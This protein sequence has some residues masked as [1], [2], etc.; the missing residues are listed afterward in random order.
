MIIC[1]VRSI[2]HTSILYIGC[3]PSLPPLQQANFQFNAPVSTCM[4]LIVRT[5]FPHPPPI[6]LQCCSRTYLEPQR[7]GGG[8]RSWVNAERTSIFGKSSHR[9]DLPNGGILYDTTSST[10]RCG[11]SPVVETT[12][13]VVYQVYLRKGLRVWYHIKPP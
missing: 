10:D 9:R 8:C 12:A 2:I 5:F 4:I 6:N 7:Q 11:T 13:A 3:L 1:A